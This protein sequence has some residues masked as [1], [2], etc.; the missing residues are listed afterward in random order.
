MF[1]ES[2]NKHTL[3]FADEFLTN[4]K[5]P[6]IELVSKNVGYLSDWYLETVT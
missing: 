4:S 5:G 6:G 3:L 1:I 2:D